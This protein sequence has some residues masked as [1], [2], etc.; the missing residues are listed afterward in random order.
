MAITTLP[1]QEY[2]AEQVDIAISYATLSAQF[3][4]GYEQTAA[5]GINT[6]QQTWTVAYTTM[7]ETQSNTVLTFLDSVGGHLPFYATPKGALQQTWR[8]IPTSLKVQHVAVSNVD[9]K[10]YR[11]I[12]FQ[13]KRAFL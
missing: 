11:T 2:I 5:D 9:G 4:D 12:T 8:L 13:L 3:G 10:V 6:K 1:L 7:N